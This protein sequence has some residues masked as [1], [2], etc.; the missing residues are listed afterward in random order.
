MFPECAFRKQVARWGLLQRCSRYVTAV[1]AAFSYRTL[2][3]V[4][5]GFSFHAIAITALLRLDNINLH[6]A[7]LFPPAQK[8]FLALENTSSAAARIRLLVKTDDPPLMQRCLGLNSDRVISV[9]VMTCMV[10]RWQVTTSNVVITLNYRPSLTRN[11]VKHG[12]DRG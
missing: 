5:G 9:Q 1:V 12:G 3:D 7:N 10:F 8:L 4:P 6:T 11:G 2:H